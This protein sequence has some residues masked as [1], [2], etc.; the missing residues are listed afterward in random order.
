MPDWSTSTCAGILPSWSSLTSCPY[1]FW[2]MCSGSGNPINW[3]CSSAQNLIKSSGF[4]DPIMIISV[5]NFTKSWYSWCNC[6]R[7]LRL[8][9]QEKLRLKTS[10][11]F[12]RSVKSESEM[13]FPLKSREVNSDACWCSS[14]LDMRVSPCSNCSIGNYNTF[15][16]GRSYSAFFVILPLS[17][18]SV[19][20]F[21]IRCSGLCWSDE[22]RVIVQ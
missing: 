16:V 20:L 17:R 13:L 9:G 15:N 2:T 11:T 6:T 12:I 5:F 7:C 10:S 4:S 19:D 22:K 3:K 1:K 21:K 18:S 14:T 8:K